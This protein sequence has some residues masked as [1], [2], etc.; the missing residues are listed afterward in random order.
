MMPST[1]LYCIRE[2]HSIG[3]V[4]SVAP[5]GLSGLTQLGTVENGKLVVNP[6]AV[7]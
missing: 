4:V 2:V 5:D 6:N 1:V 7:R 3:T